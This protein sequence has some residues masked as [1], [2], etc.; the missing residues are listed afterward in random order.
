MLNILTCKD[1]K[2]YFLCQI[3]KFN[4]MLTRLMMYIDCLAVNIWVIPWKS[5]YVAD[6]ISC[7]LHVEKFSVE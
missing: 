1:T 5:L 6:E 2:L 7:E 3:L 4:A